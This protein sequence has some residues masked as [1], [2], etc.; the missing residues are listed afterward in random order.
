M[1]ADHRS[2]SVAAA[3]IDKREKAHVPI[4]D[5]R[6]LLTI[7]EA[8]SLYGVSAQTLRL[9]CRRKFIVSVRQGFGW[10]RIVKDSIES[11]LGVTRAE[12]IR[13][14]GEK[15]IAVYARRSSNGTRDRVALDEQLRELLSFCQ[16]NYG[17]PESRVLVYRE[18]T[19]GVSMSFR[20]RKEFARL[21]RDVGEGRVSTIVIKDKS[22]LARI[23]C[24]DLIESYLKANGVNLVFVHTWNEGDQ[25][26]I[27][28][29]MGLLLDY[30]Q[31]FTSKRS[32]AKMVYKK[33]VL[34][35][36]ETRATILN[37]HKQ[38][39]SITAIKDY[40]AKHGI[41][42]RRNDGTEQTLS[43]NG[44]HRFLSKYAALPIEKEQNPIDRFAE[45]RLTKEP[46]N[47][48]LS[49]EVYRAYAEWCRENSILTTSHQIVSV[50][51]VKLGYKLTA[52][53]AQKYFTGIRFTERKK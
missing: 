1:A 36:G 33:V 39:L 32:A 12:E 15:R 19:S 49:K 41:K 18:Q 3:P 40:C 27:K 42:G 26:E 53:D 46:G 30:L 31:H 7:G 43:R 50:R 34:I 48:I 28:D 25:D 22:R 29:E 16:Q 17:V 38:G 13:K 44:I 51:L 5:S 14:E 6:K 4:P 23:D 21:W 10:N 37:L 8:V 9:W 24:H 52:R 45:E 11:Y 2:K 35:E 20:T 47:L